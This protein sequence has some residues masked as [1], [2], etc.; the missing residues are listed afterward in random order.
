MGG[1][2]H[3][4]ETD[5]WYGIPMDIGALDGEYVKVVPL[6]LYEAIFLLGLAAF[7]IVRILQKKGMAAP[8]Y[9]L[10]YGVWR[11]FIEFFR[12]DDRG[13]S[14][15]PALSPSQVTALFLILV[16]IGI[17][18]A[19]FIIRKKYGADFFQKLP[20]EAESSGGGSKQE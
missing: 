2:C 10:I 5:A 1:C 18:C 9:F 16:G 6:Q 17:Y 3:G 14:F 19:Y 7:L 20:K 13:A 4:G 8:L 11:F 12:A 15:I